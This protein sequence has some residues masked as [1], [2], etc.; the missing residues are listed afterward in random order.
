MNNRKDFFLT[1]LEAE[2]SRMKASANLVYD[3]SS[4]CV[5]VPDFSLYLLMAES[6]RELSLG[7]LYEGTNAIHESSIFM[8]I[9]QG[10]NSYNHMEG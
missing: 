5:Q 2:K 10:A 7:F 9:S 3:E 6:G 8:I 1:V 4:S